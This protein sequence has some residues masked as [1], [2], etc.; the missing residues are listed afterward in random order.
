MSH[1]GMFCAF[2]LTTVSEAEAAW[3][4]NRREAVAYLSS[5]Y[6]FLHGWL[7]KCALQYLKRLQYRTEKLWEIWPQTQ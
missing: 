7:L 6:P 3:A 1:R 2:S 5:T 4:T